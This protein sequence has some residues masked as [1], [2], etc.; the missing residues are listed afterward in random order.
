MITSIS[1]DKTENR[2]SLWHLKKPYLQ[3]YILKGDPALGFSDFQW[4]DPGKSL[5]G[6]QGSNL[7]MYDL[8]YE[9]RR[10]MYSDE[11]IGRIE[12]PYSRISTTSFDMNLQDEIAIFS[13]RIVTCEEHESLEFA[14]QFLHMLKKDVN[15]DEFFSVTPDQQTSN[16]NHNKKTEIF[17]IQ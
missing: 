5:L 12:R 17:N 6:A 7:I 13:D 4:I 11:E 1:T 3:Q 8:E 9:S 16:Q 2:V 10:S 14:D 15:V